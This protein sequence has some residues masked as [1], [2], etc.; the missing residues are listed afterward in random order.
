LNQANGIVLA[1]SR[2][3]AVAKATGAAACDVVSVNSHYDGAGSDYRTGRI[4]KHGSD[5][6]YLPAR[7]DYACADTDYQSALNYYTAV[8]IDCALLRSRYSFAL[9]RYAGRRSELIAGGSSYA[10]AVCAFCA[11]QCA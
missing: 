1:G 11:A 6:H 10:E 3:H 2:A 8:A 4:H 9:S 5:S 7:S